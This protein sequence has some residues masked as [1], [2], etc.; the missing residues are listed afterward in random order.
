VI[1][2]LILNNLVLIDSCEISFGPSFNAVTGET[3]AGKTALIEAIGLA[4]GG[5]ADSSLIRKGCE[6]AYVEMSFD[7]D[8]MPHVKEII[9]ES[10]LTIEEQEYLVIRREISKEGKNRAFINCRTAPLPLLQKI[11]AELIDMIGQHAHQ[12]LRAA[13]SQRALLDLFGCFQPQ[14]KDFQASFTKEREYQKK[15]EALQHLSSHRE[16]DENTWRFQLEE[17]ETA[18]LK[19]GEEEAAFEKY[20]RLAHAQEL[21]EKIDMMIKGLS[22]SSSSTLPQVSKFIKICDSLVCYD[23]NLS[24]TSLLLHE[25]HIALNEALRSL[26]SYSQNIDIDPSA[27]QYLENRLGAISRLKRK[28]G[29]NFEEVEA[30]RNKIENELARLEN[31]SE[32]IKSAALELEAIRAETDKKA[33]QLTSQRRAAAD[34][35]QKTLSTQLQHLNMSGAELDIQISPQPR[36][37][38]GDDSVQFW[39]KANT[40]E[41]PSLVK[42]HSSGGELSRLLF[43]IK[44]A[45]AEKNNTPTLIFDEIDANV[46][47][48]TATIIGKKLQELGKCRQVICVTHF[49]QVASKADQHFGVQKIESEGRTSTQI[50]PL[51]KTQREQELLRM[52]GGTKPD[53]ANRPQTEASIS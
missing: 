14:L 22:E 32:E 21:S 50:E 24:D 17:I 7:I 13:D 1:K 4:L 3:G 52:I 34:K 33:Q 16:R 9:E 47:G 49:S 43:A 36:S 2:H 51:S 6:K 28:Y 44:I 37:N 48:K 10:G 39:L 5:R 26:Q 42:E 20:Q 27:F 18:S 45:L 35:L 38:T 15:L 23:K 30:Y 25:A 46:G 41:H 29:Q 53:F 12:T 8:S 11:G 40:G 19:Q 31:L